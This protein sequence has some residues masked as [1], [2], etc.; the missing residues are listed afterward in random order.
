M[1]REFFITLYRA[2]IRPHLEIC[3]PAWSPYLTTN[4]DSF[5]KVHRRAI[6]LVTNIDKLAYYERL[7][8]FRLY[9]LYGR[10]QRGNLIETYKILNGW[11]HVEAGN[12]FQDFS[13][14]LPEIFKHKARLQIRHRF[15]SHRVSDQWN[16]LLQ[17]MVN[18]KT[19]SQFKTR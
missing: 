14:D 6:T 12:F 5:E 15:F 19:V 2:S 16:G 8:H 17:T 11:D 9:S 1:D 4:I 18:E 13:L 10:R 3:L 7:R